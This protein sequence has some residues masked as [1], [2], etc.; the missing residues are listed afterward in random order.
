[1][2]KLNLLLVA[3]LSTPFAFSQICSN[4]GTLEVSQVVAGNPA[5]VAD[6][7]DYVTF[8]PN[9][10]NEAWAMGK[11]GG[12]SKI[13]FSNGT[14]TAVQQNT[15]FAISS[16]QRFKYLDFVT[17]N[18]WIL[19][20]DGSGNNQGDSGNIYL[21]TNQGA[22]WTPLGNRP[23]GGPMYFVK[24]HSQH[25]NWMIIGTRN[26][27][28]ITNNSG[29]TWT[30]QSTIDNPDGNVGTRMYSV[31]LNESTGK[32]TVAARSGN[33]V[34]TTVSN[35]TN[36]GSTDLSWTSEL[37]QKTMININGTPVEF[38][39]AD[40]SWIEF[41]GSTRWVA[42]SNENGGEI[43]RSIHDGPWE[44]VKVDSFDILVH[45]EARFV[46]IADSNTIVFGDD[47]GN[48]FYTS[49]ATAQKPSWNVMQANQPSPIQNG[50]ELGRGAAM[51]DKGEFKLLVVGNLK[52]PNS[53]SLMPTMN[54]VSCQ[55]QPLAVKQ[56]STNDWS[57][58]PN[59]NNGR[60]YI[61]GTQSASVSVISS[62]GLKVWS[63]DN[64]ENNQEISLEHLNSGVYFVTIQDNDLTRTEKILFIK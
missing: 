23:P 20:G 32:V 38:G 22:T 47:I 30:K 13:T 14:W 25:P 15:T 48:I 16:T 5:P 26:G 28:F 41:A 53:G 37:N 1:M 60:F 7:L 17:N 44:A 40:V 8:N 59:P 63:S 27:M 21:S 4:N 56:V 51:F 33:I 45:L 52:D 18:H 6:D 42:T 36:T 2:K 11:S 24:S 34:S 43:L 61:K 49:N 29:E 62:T 9:N 10:A 12:L 35:F 64:V 46:T 50:Y 55:Q 19:S 57:I 54:Y 31:I 39:G 3:I 58:Y